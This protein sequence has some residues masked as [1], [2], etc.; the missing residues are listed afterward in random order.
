MSQFTV[1]QYLKTQSI[2]R[3]TLNRPDKR[4]AI[5]FDLAKEFNKA[6]LKAKE[7]E[8]VR[9]LIVTGAG[10][11]FCAGIDLAY[12]RGMKPVDFRF[13]METF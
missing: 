12:F 11:A 2:A 13:F 7:N 3:I 5:N 10:N 9:A 6:L 1:I 8:E 4:N